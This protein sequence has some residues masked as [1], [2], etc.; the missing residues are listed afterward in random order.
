MKKA[1]FSSLGLLFLASMV[2]AQAMAAKAGG[3]SSPDEVRQRWVAAAN[4]KDAAGLAALYTDDALLMPAN[5][6]AVKGRAAIQNSWKGM[7]DQGAHDISLKKVGGAQAADWGYEVGTYSAMFGTSP[8][9]GKYML[10]LKRGKDGKWLIHEDI[11]NSDM[12]CAPAT[13]PA[14]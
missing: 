2:S 10:S 3:A 4:A 1:L 7:L 13:A 8:D 5:T 6:A 12:P 9:K 14:K 11:F